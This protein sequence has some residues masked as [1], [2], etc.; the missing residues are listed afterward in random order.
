MDFGIMYAKKKT[1]AQPKTAPM[2]TSRVA[3]KLLASCKV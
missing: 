3:F 2:N 1:N